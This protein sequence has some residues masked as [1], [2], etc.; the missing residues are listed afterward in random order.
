ML[1]KAGQIAF[2]QTLKLLHHLLAFVH[3][4][5]TVHPKHDFDLDFQGQYAAKR[6]VLRIHESTAVHVDNSV[7]HGMGVSPHCSP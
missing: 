4:I 5:E 7:K 3:G 1:G 2:G 6:F